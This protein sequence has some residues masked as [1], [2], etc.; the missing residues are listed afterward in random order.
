MSGCSSEALFTLGSPFSEAVAQEN[1]G[2]QQ[3][4]NRTYVPCD[5]SSGSMFGLHPDGGA[6]RDVRSPAEKHR[7]RSSRQVGRHRMRHL[8]FSGIFAFGIDQ[9]ISREFL[10]LGGVR[11]CY[12]VRM[13]VFHG[14]VF[15]AGRSNIPR[16]GGGFGPARPVR[17]EGVPSS[18]R[19]RFHGRMSYRLAICCRLDI[20][21]DPVYRVRRHWCR[22]RAVL[23]P[24]TS[25]EFLVEAMI[26]RVPNYRAGGDAGTALC[27]CI[28]RLWP[29]A[30]HHGCSA[31]K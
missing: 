23:R 11:S 9:D 4:L 22:C 24:F 5:Q 18:L 29:G 12:D 21:E 10:G 13:V 31:K 25:G 17:L 6:D 27:S 14:M 30:P 8:Q 28:Q 19:H 2:R 1:V 20:N 15:L 7:E 3:S 26:P 16:R